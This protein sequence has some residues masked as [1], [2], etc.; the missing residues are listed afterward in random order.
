MTTKSKSEKNIKTNEIKW[1][2]GEDR[3]GKV[4]CSVLVLRKAVHDKQ[5][6]KRGEVVKRQNPVHSKAHRHIG[7]LRFKK[8]SKKRKKQTK[9]AKGARRIYTNI[10][11]KMVPCGRKKKRPKSFHRNLTVREQRRGRGQKLKKIP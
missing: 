9:G 10:V 11:I 2:R 5:A 7:E 8:L 3:K 1:K 6:E 4:Q